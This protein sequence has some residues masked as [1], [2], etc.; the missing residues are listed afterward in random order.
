MD[1]TQRVSWNA[2]VFR[3]E[4]RDDILFVTADQTG[5]GFFK[6]FGETRREG[7]EL[8]A[9]SQ[10]G[11]FTLGAGYTFLN[12]TFQSGETVNGE[13]NS[14]NDAAATES[15]GTRRDDRDRAGGPHSA[16]P[17]AHAEGVLRA[18]GH[19]GALR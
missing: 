3:A 19:I 5:F 17:P 12:A 10:F 7:L 6:N 18:P 15:E 1:N 9:T 13:S 2:G 4:N 11:R 16:H 8:G 14:T